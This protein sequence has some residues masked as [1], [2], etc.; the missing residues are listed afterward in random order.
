LPTSKVAPVHAF[1]RENG[2]TVSI[3]EGLILRN[4]QDTGPEREVLYCGTPVGVPGKARGDRC[5]RIS[6][7]R[8][9]GPLSGL[10]SRILD[11]FHRHLLCWDS[12]LGIYVERNDVRVT[13]GLFLVTHVVTLKRR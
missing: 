9:Q 8:C 1:L 13:E 3:Y 7:R 5:A 6:A 12:V 10:C 2:S 11:K 4:P